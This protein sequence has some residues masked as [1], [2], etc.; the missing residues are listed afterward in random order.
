MLHCLYIIM[1]SK[2]Q[3]LTAIDICAWTLTQG[4]N[5][6]IM[7]D[8]FLS[9]MAVVQEIIMEYESLKIKTKANI[10]EIN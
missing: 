4:Y 3:S 6:I 5:E 2:L 8:V 1:V 9:L 7:T 10:S